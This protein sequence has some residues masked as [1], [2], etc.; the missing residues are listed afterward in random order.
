M[1]KAF[2]V[3]A[4][5]EGYPPEPVQRQL[6]DQSIGPPDVLRARRKFGKSSAEPLV[7]PADDRAEVRGDLGKVGGHEAGGRG[8]DPSIEG[9][10]LAVAVLRAID[11]GITGE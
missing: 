1:S 2:V 8:P 11:V 10:E 3:P 9:D 5:V 7:D 6:V 4:T